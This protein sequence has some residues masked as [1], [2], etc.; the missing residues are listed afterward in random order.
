M[1]NSSWGL[2]LGHRN[3]LL[4]PT[5]ARQCHRM[6]K[7]EGRIWTAAIT[8]SRAA[9]QLDF[10][11]ALE[12]PIPRCPVSLQRCAPWQRDAVDLYLNAQRSNLG[13][14]CPISSTFS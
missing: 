9:R 11:G 14:N 6:T 2:T 10:G 5:G 13:A 4:V 7:D 1:V 12:P 8:R 3:I